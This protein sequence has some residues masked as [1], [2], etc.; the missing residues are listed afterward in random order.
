MK[1]RGS[2]TFSHM[3]SL[4]QRRLLVYNVFGLLP[5]ILAFFAI[6]WTR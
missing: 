1:F 5:S 6:A 3:H 2:F 4:P